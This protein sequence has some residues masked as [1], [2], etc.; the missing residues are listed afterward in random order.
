MQV[1]DNLAKSNLTRSVGKSPKVSDLRGSPKKGVERHE[2]FQGG[3]R[4]PN[5]RM[6]YQRDQDCFGDGIDASKMTED[7]D[8]EKNLALFDKRLVFREIEMENNQPDVV[9]LV[10]CNLR[11]KNATPVSRTE[12]EP[13]YRN[14]Q[15]VLATIPAQY[16]QIALDKG[17]AASN[18][19]EYSTDNG[20]V[21]P[22][23]AL[24]LRDRLMAAAEARGISRDRL[25]ETMAR[26]V[27]DMTIQMLGGSRRLNPDNSHQV[28][29]VVA[30][31][32]PGKAGAYGLAAL[33]HLVSQGVNTCAYVPPFPMYPPH[34]DSE[35]NLYKLCVKKR[36]IVLVN[37]AS[38]LPSA[39]DVVL[40]ALDDHEM[41]E[42]ERSQRWHR[43]AIHWAK[44]HASMVIALD[45]LTPE[46]AKAEL[47]IKASV[48]PGLPL[49]YPDESMGKLYMANL[50]LPAKVFKDVGITYSSP[51]GAKTCITLNV[52][53]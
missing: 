4:T 33:R 50:A 32:G 41:L 11:N 31:C 19:G 17:V 51:F 3:F 29:R 46:K 22:G 44:K 53:K 30:L 48:L 2:S 18:R 20:L 7:F 24:G 14:D 42:Q 1:A 49:W 8:F 28:P 34:I 39:A 37:D 16:R 35:L 40:L 47:N 27:S 26:C 5:K 10:D 36:D 25:V 43:A 52:L 45:P 9:R 15:N 21:V 6:Q 12:M 23:I 13:K 38:D